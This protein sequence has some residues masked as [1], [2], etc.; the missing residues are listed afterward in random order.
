ME[1]KFVRSREEAKT[2]ASGTFEDTAGYRGSKD[3]VRFYSVIYQVQ[4]IMLESHLRHDLKRL[5]AATWTPIVVNGSSD[6]TS[7]KKRQGSRNGDMSK[8]PAEPPK[9]LA[10]SFNNLRGLYSD[11]NEEHL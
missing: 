11:Q 9:V 10:G 3:W 7:D 6:R 8:E 5:G 2:A 1:F 4:P